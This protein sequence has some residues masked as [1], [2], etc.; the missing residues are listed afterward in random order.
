[1]ENVESVGRTLMEV[2]GTP[3]SARLKKVKWTVRHLHTR[4]WCLETSGKS[5]KLTIGNMSSPGNADYSMNKCFRCSN[6]SNQKAIRDRSSKVETP[7][8]SVI[9]SWTNP[10]VQYPLFGPVWPDVHTLVG[11]TRSRCGLSVTSGL[12]GNW[13][14]TTFRLIEIRWMYF[15][16]W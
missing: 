15:D 16:T 14:K 5:P 11:G 4:M 2:K 9:V 12:S 6:E 7:W 1:M 13:G 3:E 10:G 8:L